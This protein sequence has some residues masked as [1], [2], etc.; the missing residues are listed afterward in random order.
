MLF[1]SWEFVALLSVTVALY[2]LSPVLWVRHVLLLVANIIFY[3]TW[4][5]I[6]LILL[7]GLVLLCWIASIISHDKPRFVW[8]S[9]FAIVSC[10]AA[11][12]FFKYANFASQVGSDLART[13]GYSGWDVSYAIILPLGISFYVFHLIAYV[14]DVRRGVAEPERNPIIF[15]VFVTYFP[16]LIAGPICRAHELLPE[17][18]KKK[19]FSLRDLVHG[20]LLC[21]S[22]LFLKVAIADNLKPFVDSVFSMPAEHAGVPALIGILGFG[23]VILCDF[24]GY[25][26]IAAG[27]ALM[28]GIRIPYNFKLPYAATSLQDFW[29]RWHIT[30]SRWLR[31]YLYVPLGGSRKGRG[32]T[33]LNLFIT[34]LLGGLWHGAAYTFIIWGAIH[35]GWLTLERVFREWREKLPR[36][37]G[38]V[39][40]LELIAGWG[41]TMLVV[42]IAWVFFRA[43]SVE[44]ALDV[45]RHAA[46]LNIAAPPA[47]KVACAFIG[48][49]LLT[50][51][52]LHLFQFDERWI[53]LRISLKLAIAGWLLIA[54]AILSSGV[55][56]QFIYFQF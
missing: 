28:M 27:A 5:P 8:A 40:A 16:Q 56:E 2:W 13:L 20:F 49:F 21:A 10:L 52:P 12:A 53:A 38:W 48:I 46:V 15:T 50:L 11:L 54:M 45:L 25:S 34:F 33:Y 42:F 35:G 14:V 22:G 43:A 4:Q 7:I 47:M 6:F 51:L 41:V 9:V 18:K 44:N 31:D 3:A 19:I 17:L 39:R 37:G 29:R 55:V 32:R 36:G 1:N 30:L 23:V 26:T 24:W